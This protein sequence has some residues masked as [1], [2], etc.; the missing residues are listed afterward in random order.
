MSDIYVV[1]DVDGVLRLDAE[2]HA[3]TTASEV[4]RRAASTHEA[5]SMVMAPGTVIIL[6]GRQGVRHGRVPMPLSPKG[7]G[8]GDIGV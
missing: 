5:R 7:K 6:V 1:A 8:I 4:L 2:V 3:D